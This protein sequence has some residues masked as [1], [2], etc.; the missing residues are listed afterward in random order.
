MSQLPKNDAFELLSTV[1]E[2][3]KR[4]YLHPSL[5]NGKFHR[6][7]RAVMAVL[8]GFYVVLPWVDIGGRQGFLLDIGRRE[9]A[10]FGLHFRAH[11]MPL[12]VFPLL[13]WVFL[14][15][16]VTSLFGRVW[17][18]W[19]CPQTVFIEAVFRRI[20]TWTEGGPLQRK[21][22]DQ[23]PLSFAKFFRRASKWTLFVLFSLWITHTA[24]ALFIGRDRLLL[25]ITRSPAE[26]WESFLFIAFATTIVLIDFG[27][28]REQFCLLACPYGRIQSLFTDRDTRTILYDE[29][30]GEPRRGLVPNGGKG[31]DCVNCLRCVQVCPTGIDI[32]RASGQLECIGCTA[33]IDACDE[34]MTK[35]HKPCGLIRYDS[36]NAVAGDA[37]PWL[38]PRVIA[39]A[40]L[41]ATVSGLFTVT[42]ITRKPL[43]TTVLK[44]RGEPFQKFTGPDGTPWIANAFH[45]E[46][47]NQTEEELTVSISLVTP[48]ESLRLVVPGNPFRLGEKEIRQTPLV[49]EARSPRLAGGTGKTKL[50]IEARG[51][52]TNYSTTEEVTLV[53]PYR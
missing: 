27:W 30:R 9:F 39:Y 49:V 37:S 47:G 44:T 53:G 13:G 34:V 26:N 36:D 22:L 2:H 41:L 1:D 4:V 16:L 24:L 28:L 8:L 10:L 7:R 33:C 17:C 31:G 40:L 51:A 14:V 43:S 12:V 45:A 19:A 23:E 6:A 38:R 35:L 3:G 21:K 50:R 32:R 29:K 42:L 18:G 52:H 46:L 48:E 5:V 11:D 20:E 15:A 25:A